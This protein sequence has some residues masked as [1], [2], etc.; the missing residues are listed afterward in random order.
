[1]TPGGRSWSGD[2]MTF[3]QTIDEVAEDLAQRSSDALAARRA[4]GEVM[5]YVRAGWV[6]REYP[7]W[8]VERLC[9]ADEFKAADY[10][11][12]ST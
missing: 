5:T 3:R 8:M 4:R 7:G 9:P 2:G 12:R 1:M 10:P 11:P 6:W